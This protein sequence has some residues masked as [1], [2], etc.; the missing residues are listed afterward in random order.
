MVMGDDFELISYLGG[1]GYDYSFAQKIQNGVLYLAGQT[2]SPHFM[3]S[4]GAFQSA[5]VGAEDGFLWVMDYD[6]YLSLDHET[7]QGSSSM[8]PELRNYLSFGFVVVV[9]IVWYLY[10]KR[11]FKSNG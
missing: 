1:T 8:S 2:S 4:D 5:P 10:M 6:T 7:D 11:Y 9:I 3:V